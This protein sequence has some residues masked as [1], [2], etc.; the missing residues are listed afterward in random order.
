MW[1]YIYDFFY[2]SCNFWQVRV[3]RTKWFYGHKCQNWFF[4][5]LLV[6]VW[7]AWYSLI[8]FGVLLKNHR[9]I[10]PSCTNT[11]WDNVTNCQR[12][13]RNFTNTLY[14]KYDSIYVEVWPSLVI[15]CLLFFRITDSTY[16]SPI[17]KE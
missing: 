10:L 16:T 13:R 7:F 5:A 11:F 4:D 15:S 6:S 17:R 2:K 8:V 1:L 3:D 14:V 9:W 12:T